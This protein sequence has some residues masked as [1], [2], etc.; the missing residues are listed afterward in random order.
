GTVLLVSHDRVFL[1][2]VV[3]S[4]LAFEGEGRVTEYVGGYDDYLRQRGAARRTVEDAGGR[5]EKAD[6]AARKRDKPR[7]LSYNEQR[8]LAGLPEKI[9]ALEQEEARLKDEAAS[10]EFYRSPAAHIHGVLARL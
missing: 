7:R 2:R 1:D 6:T 3:T 4:T 8:E 9:A 10:P 5:A